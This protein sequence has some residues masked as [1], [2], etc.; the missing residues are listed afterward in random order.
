MIPN[1]LSGTDD[2][3]GPLTEEERLGLIPSYVTTREELNEAEQEN[4]TL[5]EDWAFSRHRDVLD[6]RFLRRLH[7]EMLK[8]VWKWAGE[9][10]TTGKNIGV[11][12]WR[13]NPDLQHTLND[14][15]YWVEHQTYSP[16]EIAMR[17]HHRLVFIHPFPNGNGRHARIAADLLALHLKRP[18]FT[19]GRQSIVEPGETRQRYIDALRAADNHDIAPLLSFARS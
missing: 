14:V 9:Y 3:T 16:D 17:F 7:K 11:D 13:I 2:G 10:R 15:R 1:P 12:A 8:N 5:A 6:E 18:R 4:I 19:W